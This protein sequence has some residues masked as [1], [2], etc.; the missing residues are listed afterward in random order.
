MFLNIKLKLFVVLLCT[1]IVLSVRDL[2]IDIKMKNG[3]SFFIYSKVAMTCAWLFLNSQIIEAVRDCL[4]PKFFIGSQKC[5]KKCFFGKSFN[6][7]CSKICTTH[8]VADSIGFE[9]ECSPYS[10]NSIK[11]TCSIKRPRTV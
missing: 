1:E 2:S 5:L 11:G 7:I 4:R 6:E 9:L 10:Y 3:L 8:Y